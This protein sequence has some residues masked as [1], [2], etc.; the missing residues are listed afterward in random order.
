MF[1]AL[2]ALLTSFACLGKKT[3]RTASSATMQGSLGLHY[4]ND[5]VP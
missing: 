3:Q 1:L 2:L 5:L 4:L